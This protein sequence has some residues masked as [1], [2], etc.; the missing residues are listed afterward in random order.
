ME[1]S[2]DAVPLIEDRQPTDLVVQ[3]GTVD[4]DPCVER[5]DLDQRLVIRAE[6]DGALLIGQVQPADHLVLDRDRD[7]Q[8]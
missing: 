1:V 4:G 5:E 6:I 7:A 3:P 2:A 8:E